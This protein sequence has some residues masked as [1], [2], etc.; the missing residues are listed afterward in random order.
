V[1]TWIYLTFF[2]AAFP[3]LGFAECEPV[4]LRAALGPP[5]DQGDTGWCYAQTAADLLTQALGTRISAAAIASDSVLAES[6][7]IEHL[8]RGPVKAYLDKNF[9]LRQEIREIRLAEPELWLDK[10]LF[11]Y[12][13]RDPRD[14]ESEIL[15]RGLFNVGGSESIAL[16]VANLYGICPEEKLPEEDYVAWADLLEQRRL[17]N[18]ARGARH[19]R[20]FVNERCGKRYFLGQPLLAKNS[21]IAQD[22]ND[23]KKISLKNPRRARKMQAELWARIEQ[24]LNRGVASAVGYDYCEHALS[25]SGECSESLNS[26]GER[27]APELDHS[28]VIAARRKIG[29]QCQFFLRNTVG[30][31]CEFIHS[32]F[33][34][35]CEKEAGGIW[36]T[37]A[38]LK[39]LYSVVSAEPTT[40]DR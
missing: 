30:P 5:R 34:P 36:I 28:A 10:N 13:S 15:F 20:D 29:G 17:A 21:Q 31:T 35:R 12:E 40:S 38:E 3:S 18:P 7:E 32:R 33:E 6:R 37:R 27:Q 8:A 4:D 19:L 26:R 22:A 16:L 14:P 39:T 11:A 2:W 23:W 24:N 1:R 25:D 9:F